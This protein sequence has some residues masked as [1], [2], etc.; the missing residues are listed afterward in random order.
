[1]RVLQKSE[2]CLDSD[3]LESLGNPGF[4]QRRIKAASFIIRAIRMTKKKGK[5]TARLVTMIMILKIR[6]TTPMLAFIL[7]PQLRIKEVLQD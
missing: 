3:N 5:K 4:E 1:M 6:R 7:S 2:A